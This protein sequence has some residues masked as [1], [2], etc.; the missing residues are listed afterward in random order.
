MDLQ[1]LLFMFFGGLGI[2][3]FGLKFMSDGLTKIAGDRLRELLD[4]FTS[5]PIKGVLTGIVVTVLLQSSTSTTVLTIGLVNAG[6]MTLRQAIGVIMG[7]N[8]GTTATAFIIGIDITEYALPIVFIGTFFIFFFKNRTAN[9]YGQV[10]FG[11]GALFLGLNIMGNGV[12]PLADSQVFEE[13]TV[14]M[15]ETPILGVIIGTAF[16]VIVQ[17]STA[18][19]G[20]LQQLYNAGAIDLQ[21]A[22]PVLFGDNIGTTVTAVLAS[23]GASVAA[24]R[25]AL[26]HVIFNLV[27]AVVILILLQ[28]FTAFM[29]MLEENL[30]LVPP[31]TIAVAHGSFN[32]ANLLIQVSFIGVLATIVTKLI[33]GKDTEID[34]KAKHLDPTFIERSPAI[35]LGQARSEVLR[36]ADFAQQG[37]YEV[38]KYIKGHQRKNAERA[39]QYEEAIN[40]LDRE[41]TNYLM[42]ISNRSLSS[43]NS[44]VH[45]ALFNTVRDI[46]RIGDHF[47]NMMELVDYQ[48]RNKVVLSEAAKD[49]LDEMVSLTLKTL[50]DAIYALEHQD[51]DAARATEKQEEEIDKL[52]RK[53]RR[54]HIERM[55]DGRCSGS[56]GIVFVDIISNLERIG[57]HAVNIAEAVLNKH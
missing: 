53:M 15:S 23:I 14:S 21:A 42:Q 55:N 52:E 17:S 37:L 8:V 44:Y 24:K 46:E 26:S 51:V 11:F 22:L 19:I 13:L 49:D 12:S 47:E 4:R 34:H 57:D 25:T 29:A 31:M 45:S 39:S 54:K 43:E 28:P 33:P 36:M 35:A 1:E 6:F 20:L 5:N 9:N 7:A 38:N 40:H 30:N 2:F 27:G 10:I 32:V 18:A 48:M 3:L 50:Q 16:T 41:I 56:A